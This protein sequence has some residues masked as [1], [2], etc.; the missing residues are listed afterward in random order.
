[1]LIDKFDGKEASDNIY[2]IPIVGLDNDFDYVYVENKRKFEIENEDH[3]RT[4]LQESQYFCPE[5]V[6]PS[7][8]GYKNIAKAIY[9][10]IKYWGGLI[11]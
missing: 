11:N 3:T 5:T 4:I 6:H 7:T 8:L 2:L 10:Y 9:P 1:M